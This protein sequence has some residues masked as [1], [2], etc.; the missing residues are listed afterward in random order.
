[1]VSKSIT[2]IVGAA[3]G[4]T[5]LT[6][7]SFAILPVAVFAAVS[8]GVGVVGGALGA[9]KIYDRIANRNELIETEE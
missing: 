2:S 4:A 3:I 9:G 8:F 1:M 6:G 5:C 7:L